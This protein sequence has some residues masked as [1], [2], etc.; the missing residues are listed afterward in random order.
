M[1]KLESHVWTPQ[2]LG[3]SAH[4]TLPRQL[5]PL[6]TLVFRPGLLQSL[7]DSDEIRED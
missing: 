1:G 4:Q 2:L 7:F 5:H 3:P 6:V